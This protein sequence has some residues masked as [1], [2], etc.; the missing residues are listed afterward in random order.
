MVVDSGAI[1][2]LT[3]LIGTTDA[4]LKRQVTVTTLFLLTNYLSTIFTPSHLHTI[5]YLGVQCS[6][7][8]LETQ[9]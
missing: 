6:E 5:T 8:D 3:Q 2:H 4:K 9:C 1:A 7:S